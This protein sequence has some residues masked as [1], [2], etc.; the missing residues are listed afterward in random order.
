L[1]KA[2]LVKLRLYKILSKNIFDN[3]IIKYKIDISKIG[4]FMIKC[5]LF[6]N[7]NNLSTNEYDFLKIFNC[8]K[9]TFKGREKHFVIPQNIKTFSVHQITKGKKT[10]TVDFN[11][12][13][14]N[15]YFFLNKSNRGNY[16]TK[17]SDDSIYTNLKLMKL[18]E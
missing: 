4:S 7:P 6:F 13:F 10:F 11:I 5:K 14:F 18:I 8:D 9:I 12:L 2:I 1:K 15:H 17:F 16:K 3:L